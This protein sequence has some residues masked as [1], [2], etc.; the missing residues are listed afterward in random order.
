M[1]CL[2]DSEIPLYR[3][4]LTLN[5]NLASYFIVYR[6]AFIKNG[7]PLLLNSNSMR[8]NIMHKV[9]KF[10]NEANETLQ[11]RINNE[12][13][14]IELAN[15]INYSKLLF[16]YSSQLTKEVELKVKNILIY[17]NKYLKKLIF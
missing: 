9:L 6:I 16:Y 13:G 12:N 5:I 4:K 14:L 15:K 7:S 1:H 11:L 17:A 10:Y 3:Y 8:L 2:F